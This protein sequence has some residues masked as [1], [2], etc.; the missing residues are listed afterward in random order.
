MSKKITPPK[1]EKDTPYKVWKNKLDMWAL[2]CGVEKKEQAIYVLLHD[3]SGNSKAEKAVA[4][5]TKEELNKDDGLK[6]LLKVLDNAFEAE[7]IED[8][9]STYAA[10]N[11]F[12]KKVDVSIADYIL[13]FEQLNQ[14]MVISIS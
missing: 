6:T 5:L 2:I 9:Y 1:L 13:E 4:S 8:A 7:R 10:F 14:K 12:K 11:N 3:L